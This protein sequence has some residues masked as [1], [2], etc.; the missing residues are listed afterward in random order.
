MGKYKTEEI[1]GQTV[2]VSFNT[3]AL[4]DFTNKTGVPLQ[5]IGNFM[6]WERKTI[7]ELIYQ[8]LK[9]GHKLAGEKL[10]IKKDDIMCIPFEEFSKYIQ[11]LGNSLSTTTNQKKMKPLPIPE[12]K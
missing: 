10:T 9:E 7:T 5:D 4:W 11:I 8:G 1:D 2:Y 3:G 12:G 6:K